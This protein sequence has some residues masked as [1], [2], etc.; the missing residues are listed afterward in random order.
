MLELATR[1]QEQA[2]ANTELE[3][4]NEKHTREALEDAT[5]LA[6]ELSLSLKRGLMPI[7]KIDLV[8]VNAYALIEAYEC[9]SFT[10][11]GAGVDFLGLNPHRPRCRIKLFT[12]VDTTTHHSSGK[13]GSWR[14]WQVVSLRSTADV[15]A[16]LEIPLTTVWVVLHIGICFDEHDQHIGEPEIFV[17]PW[18]R[19]TK[20]SNKVMPFVLAVGPQHIATSEHHVL[21]CRRRNTHLNGYLSS[22]FA[23]FLDRHKL[24][25]VDRFFPVVVQK[26]PKSEK[27]GP[28]IQTQAQAPGQQEQLTFAKSKTAARSGLRQ[29]RALTQEQ[30]EKLDGCDVLAKDLAEAEALIIELKDQ[31]AA[32]KA[33]KKERD[34]RAKRRRPAP[35][36][37][38]PQ[39]ISK[40]IVEEAIGKYYR[41][42]PK[43]LI[44]SC[45]SL[46]SYVAMVIT[47]T[48]THSFRRIFSHAYIVSHLT[49]HIDS[50]TD[51]IQEV[52]AD[53]R[54]QK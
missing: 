50:P 24:D 45:I 53:F 30:Q 35:N 19:I 23:N 15:P 38:K 27:A 9:D 5:R 37:T 48:H 29:A 51:C 4:V 33:A 31:I 26:I 54:A 8:G 3:T 36:R 41:E 11:G 28:E 43:V 17:A 49:A 40:A 6:D 14:R 42:H 52:D 10:L 34:G 39:Y 18:Q 7:R 2:A 21:P 25:L 20:K 16:A 22:V 44:I 47:H 13:K 1:A 12:G 32:F 46:H